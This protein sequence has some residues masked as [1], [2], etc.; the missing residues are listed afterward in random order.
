MLF[1]TIKW[2][3]GQGRT[4]SLPW[5]LELPAPVG[6]LFQPICFCLLTDPS[7]ASLRLVLLYSLMLSI[8]TC[9]RTA[10]WSPRRPAL[11]G[12]REDIVFEYCKWI[13]IESSDYRMLKNSHFGK[14]I[15][16]KKMF[17]NKR[18]EILH[19]FYRSLINGVHGASVLLPLKQKEF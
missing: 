15:C 3:G 2:C 10:L 12:W 4:Q 13:G 11:L 9:E 14:N 6:L 1:C 19:Y 17:W 5:S 16:I 7:Q 18:N 8:W